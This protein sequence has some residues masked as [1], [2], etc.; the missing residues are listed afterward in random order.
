MT[1]TATGRWPAWCRLTSPRGTG[2]APTRRDDMAHLNRNDLTTL[3]NMVEQRLKKVRRQ[4]A[5]RRDRGQL[6]EWWDT[7][8]AQRRWVELRD[9]LEAMREE[10]EDGPA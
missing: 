7:D 3:L 8:Q 5:A 2:T 6:P 1:R 10:N 4:D 9:K